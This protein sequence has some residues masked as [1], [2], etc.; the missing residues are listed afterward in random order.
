[1]CS[2]FKIIIACFFRVFST[3]SCSN[4]KENVAALNTQNVLYHSNLYKKL[5]E[6][7]SDNVGY[8]VR[9]VLEGHPRIYCF[10]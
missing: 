3:K 6:Y 7:L 4:L 8:D 9:T 2:C 10:L 5:P 1:M